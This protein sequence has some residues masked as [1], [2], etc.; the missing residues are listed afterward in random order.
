MN[1]SP[2]AEMPKQK[3]PVTE[4]VP[5][6]RRLSIRSDQPA[7]VHFQFETP[8]RRIKGAVGGAIIG[9]GVLF[10]I[11]AILVWVVPDSTLEAVLPE[12]IPRQL[13][14]LAE[15]GPGGGGGG[16]NERPEPPKPAEVPG[17]E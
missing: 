11:W 15:P 12:Q 5:E 10:A 8:G 16:G 13:V 17:Q 7:E 9:H 4:Q 2:V 1:L 6:I 3:T 14:W